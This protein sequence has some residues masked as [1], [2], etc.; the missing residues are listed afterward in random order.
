M[1]R[2]RTPYSDLFETLKQAT[3]QSTNAASQLQLKQARLQ[4]RRIQTGAR[5]QRIQAHRVR[6][7][8]PQQRQVR[9]IWSR[10]ESP[11]GITRCIF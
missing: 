6:A 9:V 8:G 3:R 2:P 10:S 1:D 5:L 11:I 7:Q 4:C